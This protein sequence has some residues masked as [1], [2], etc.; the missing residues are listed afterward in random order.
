MCLCV[1]K[2]RATPLNLLGNFKRFS[3]IRNREILLNLIRKMKYLTDQ[4][5]LFLYSYWQR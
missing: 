3:T 5:Q 2:V 1:G 4:F